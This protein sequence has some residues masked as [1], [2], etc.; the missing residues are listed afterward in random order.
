MP[1]HVLPLLR[2]VLVCELALR[3]IFLSCVH[4][5]RH[6][7]HRSVRRCQATDTF[8][9]R[10]F[11]P[12]RWFTPH[13]RSRVYCTPKPERVRCVSRLCPTFCLPKPTSDGNQFP[14]PASAVH[15]LRRIP[16]AGSRTAS[17][18]PLP[19]CC[20]VRFATVPNTEVFDATNSACQQAPCHLPLS[21]P[22]PFERICHCVRTLTLTDL[23]CPPKRSSRARC[24]VFASPPKRFGRSTHRDAEASDVKPV[25][26][27]CRSR[28]VP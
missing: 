17:L 13:I 18:R 4:P 8:Q 16:L 24:Y 10:G 27:R 6:C 5:R 21:Q 3:P 25:S 12:P 28:V 2:F 11:S 15:T 26:P 22:K 20:S 19:S 9:P 1:K 14:F 23:A 7:C